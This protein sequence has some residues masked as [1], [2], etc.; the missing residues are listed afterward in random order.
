MRMV[1]TAVGREAAADGAASA[2]IT[3][4]TARA[5]RIAATARILRYVDRFEQREIEP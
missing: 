5:A 4:T 1:T 3:P 2:Q